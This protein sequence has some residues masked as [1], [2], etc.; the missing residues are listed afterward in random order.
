MREIIITH[1]LEDQY[2]KLRNNLDSDG[3][4]LV[5]VN[6]EGNICSLNNK[7]YEILGYEEG[8]LIGKNMFELCIPQKNREELLKV[9]KAVV[10]GDEELNE[11]YL[12]PLI[13]KNGEERIISWHNALL[14]DDARKITGMLYSGQDITEKTKTEQIKITKLK[15][16]EEKASEVYERMNLY[17]SLF[18]HDIST[19]FSNIKMAAEL[20]SPYLNDPTKLGKLK[21]LHHVIEE[22]IIRGDKLIKNVNRLTSLG[23]SKFPIKRENL[24]HILNSSI[25]FLHNSFPNREI[26]VN[27]E[28]LKGKIYVNA[29]ELLLDVFENILINSVKHNI[30]PHVEINIAISKIEIEDKI[31]IKLEFKDN[32]N[33]I[34]DKRKQSIFQREKV[35]KRKEG[36]MG[37]GLSLVKKIIDSYE[38]K[39]WVEDRIKGDYKKGCNFRILIPAVN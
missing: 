7:G 25:E 6:E 16:A 12:T 23:E 29:N 34:S 8:E 11:F 38:G 15:E 27:K 24:R 31:F 35:L 33:G 5:A 13:T 20:C 36:G 4:I 39:I 14:Y 3:V 30:N 21:E 9:F 28:I 22:Q 10:K 1:H 37:L 17:R 26:D 19:I 2:D 18:A 32:G